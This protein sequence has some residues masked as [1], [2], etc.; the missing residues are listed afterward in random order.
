MAAITATWGVNIG[1]LQVKNSLGI[2]L[3]RLFLK[4]L[5]RV[6]Q[7]TAMREVQ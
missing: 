3:S 7:A 5:G 2:K 1:G 6:K 4:N